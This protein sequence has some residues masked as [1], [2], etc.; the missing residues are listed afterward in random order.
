MPTGSDASG[1]A[2]R[3]QSGAAAN[4]AGLFVILAATHFFLDAAAFHQFAEATH[5]FLDRFTIPN[6]KLDHTSSF[7][8]ANRIR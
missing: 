4:F 1:A 2:F 8:N 3:T 7:E 5:C 6:R